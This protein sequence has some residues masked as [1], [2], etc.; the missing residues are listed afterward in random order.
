MAEDTGFA[1][2]GWSLPEASFQL[3]TDNRGYGFG[4]GPDGTPGKKVF[5]MEVENYGVVGDSVFFHP[6]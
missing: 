1:R 2:F 4:A 3:G 5:N 6:A